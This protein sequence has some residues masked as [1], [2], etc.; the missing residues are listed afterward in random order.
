MRLDWNLLFGDD[1]DDDDVDDWEDDDKWLM[2]LVT[3]SRATMTLLSTYEVGG[4]Y[5]TTPETLF[6]A[7]QPFPGMTHG[8]SVPP[9]VI[10]DL[11]VRM[12][13]LE[14]RHR[15]L[16]KKIWMVSDA[17]VAD[18]I[19][20]RYIW[21]RV[22]TIEGQNQQLP[23]RLAKMESRESTLMLYML[24]MEERL[25]VLEKKLPGPPP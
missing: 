10:N 14:Y 15:A 11:C 22:T 17:Q 24:W 9:S 18:G 7:R 23:T 3:P 16:V 8:T 4:P 5:F 20:I 1:T 12:G 21:P 19:S 2:A 25:A 13:N 6:L